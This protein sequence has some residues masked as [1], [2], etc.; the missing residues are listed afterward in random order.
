MYKQKRD[1]I[2]DLALL[3]DI[4]DIECPEVRDVDVACEHGNLIDLRLQLLVHHLS[5]F[6]DYFKVRID[7]A[8]YQV[9]WHF[10]SQSLQLAD[11]SAL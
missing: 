1:R 5:L 3:V 4:V 6:S 9:V 11:A 2:L 10:L 8:Y 7:R